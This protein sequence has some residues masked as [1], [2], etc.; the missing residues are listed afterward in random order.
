MRNV[1]FYNFSLLD[2]NFIIPA[3]LSPL[4]KN[5]ISWFSRHSFLLLTTTY[6]LLRRRWNREMEKGENQSVPDPDFTVAALKL[7]GI[8]PTVVKPLR[9]RGTVKPVRNLRR[10]PVWIF[11]V[12][13]IKCSAIYNIKF[14]L[15]IFIFKKMKS[16][17]K[18]N[19]SDEQ[20]LLW[21]L[22]RQLGERFANPP[23]K[24]N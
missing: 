20:I 6:R 2:G 3:V 24:Q 16:G 18:R 1:L 13:K 17:R 14:S 5:R 7:P 10:G 12:V 9:C 23:K 4:T 11:A 8:F 21:Y 22:W 15:W 19:T